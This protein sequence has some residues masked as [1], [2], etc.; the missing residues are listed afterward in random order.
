MAIVI[1]CGLSAREFLTRAAAAGLDASRIGAILVSHEHRD[2]ISGIGPLARRLKVPV[3]SNRD[4]WELGGPM[5]GRVSHEP[6]TTGDTLTFG[7]LRVHT[8]SVSHDTP[9]PVG[10]VVESP[11]GRLGLATDLGVPSTLVRHHLQGLAALILEFN[12]DFNMLMEGPYPWP[13]KQRVRGRNG[14][15]ANDVAAELAADLYHQDLRHL[16]L[17]HLSETNNQPELAVRAAREAL[18]DALEPVPAY[19]DRPTI[20]FE[21]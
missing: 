2:H 21:F 7:P 10:F 13:L 8:F 9:D 19:Q 18:D 15:L 11:A 1:D 4:T 12:H 5:A 20:V 17:A 14:H 16:V 3:L 6:F